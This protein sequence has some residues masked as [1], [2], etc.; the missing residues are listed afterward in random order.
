MNPASRDFFEAHFARPEM[1]LLLAGCRRLAGSIDEREWEESVSAP[2]D[3][4]DFSVLCNGNR[5]S[6]VINKTLIGPHGNRFPADFAEGFGRDARRTGLSQLR[7][8][9]SMIDIHRSF[10]AGKLRH[11]FLKGPALNG[12]LHGEETLRCSSDL[13]IL[14]EPRN[15]RNADALMEEMG[16]DAVTPNAIRNLQSPF[17]GIGVKDISYRKN[18][19]G[20]AVELHWKTDKVETILNRGI[21]D[22]DAHITHVPLHHEFLPVMEP[23]HNCLYLC[24]HAAKHHWMRLQWLLDIAL[25]MQRR[26]IDGDRLLELA[27]RYGLRNVVL[28][29]YCLCRRLLRM[30]LTNVETASWERHAIGAVRRFHL[31]SQPASRRIN[32][33]LVFH[34]GL[35]YPKNGPRQG[36]WMQWILERTMQFGRKA[37]KW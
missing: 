20:P 31:A 18:H 27:D 17:S 8:A 36:Y 25:L 22:W 16:F 14:I 7:I 28:E 6:L 24:L 12:L 34:R 23:Y 30:D 37:A 3:M 19:A 4:S 29:A 21:F 33:S 9:K 2:F 26:Q 1:K 13:D 11:V 10:R 5:L 15:L 35:L 32:R